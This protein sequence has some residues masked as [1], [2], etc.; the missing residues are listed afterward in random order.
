MFGCGSSLINNR[1]VVTAAHCVTSED[2]PRRY[3]PTLVRLGEWNTATDQDC[4]TSDGTPDC[5]DEPVQDIGIAKIIAHES[6]RK[7]DPNMH[8]DI[9]LIRLRQPATFNFYVSPVCLPLTVT[10]R[11]KNP[12]NSFATVAGWGYT[13]EGE[14]VMR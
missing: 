12:I 1:F 14:F 2:I 13:E 5:V 3:Q 7:S 10:L 6:Y 9:A 11:R 8:N 4:D